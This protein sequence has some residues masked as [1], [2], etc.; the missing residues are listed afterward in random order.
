MGIP[1]IHHYLDDFIIIVPSHSTQCQQSL[2]IL[3]KVCESLG[4]PLAEH[5]R[6]GPST[7]LGI[8]IDSVRGQLHL[9]ADKLSRLQALILG[10]GNRKACSCKELEL[11]IGLLNHAYR[12]G[13][14][15]LRRM[16]DLLHATHRQASGQTW[17]V[18]KFS[19]HTGM[20][21][22]SCPPPPPPMQVP[23]KG[24]CHGIEDHCC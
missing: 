8:E 15:F 22:H 6:D 16:I 20:E 10:W 5:K 7:C 23:V 12:S 19:S 1:L 3:D 17:P 24:I 9:P 2:E 13:R 18:G 11:L 21:C 4:F 14:S